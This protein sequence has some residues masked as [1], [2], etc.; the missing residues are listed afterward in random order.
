MKIQNQQVKPTP[1]EGFPLS[2]PQA[3]A[4]RGRN[5][6][7]IANTIVWVRLD[8]SVDSQQLCNQIEQTIQQDPQFSTGFDALPGMALP[9]QVLDAN[10][11]LC[12]FFV[13]DTLIDIEQEIAR[14]SQIPLGLNENPVVAVSI[15]G[16]QCGSEG[17]VLMLA[18]A[19]FLADEA[20]L[21]I[22]LDRAAKGAEKSLADEV[23]ALRFQHFSEWANKEIQEFQEQGRKDFWGEPL[24]KITLSKINLPIATKT[25]RQVAIE[26]I[27]EDWLKKLTDYGRPEAAFLTAWGIVAGQ[28][29]YDEAES[30]TISRLATGRVFDDFSEIIGS[31]SGRTPI[32]ITRDSAQ[33]IAEVM[34]TVDEAIALHE[35][36]LIHYPDFEPVTQEPDGATLGFAWIAASVPKVPFQEV[37][38]E[39]ATTGGNLEL[40][41]EPMA[42]G[43]RIRVVVSNL[44]D[45]LEL[46]ER[47]AKAVIAAIKYMSDTPEAALSS[48]PLLGSE[49]YRQVVTTWNDT[50]QL[51]T[52]PSSIPDGFRQI[53][54]QQPAELAVVDRLGELT[55][56]ELDR[57]SE[58]LAH[59]LIHR[60]IKKETPIA[61]L[62]NRSRESI[63]S[64]LAILKAGGIYVPINPDFPQS[65]IRQMLTTAKIELM[66]VEEVQA[67][68]TQNFDL[69]LLIV[70]AQ[71]Q[72][73]NPVELVSVE[74]TPTDAAY[75]IFTSGSTGV[76]KGVLVEHRS[77]LNLWQALRARIYHNSSPPL[78]VSV[79]AP[80][81]FDAS[82]KQMLQILSGHT[83]YLVPA[84]VRVDPKQMLAFLDRYRLN[85]FDCTPS[86]LQLLINAGL[87]DHFSGLPQRIL[88]GGEPFTPELWNL[89]SS[90]QHT[91]VFNLY[92]PTEATVNT[93]VTEVNLTEKQPNIGTPLPNVRVYVLDSHGRPKMISAP[94]EL[95]IAG[96]GIA[97]GY[98]NTAK[99]ASS[100]FTQNPFSDRVEKMYR[101]GDRVHWRSDGRL[102]F[103]GRADRQIKLKGYRI[104]LGDIDNALV[105]HPAVNESVTVL[106]EE[107]NGDSYLA[108]YAVLDPQAVNLDSPSKLDLEIPTG[109]IVAS[110]NQHETTYLYKE[111]FV[112]RCYLRNGI[113]LPADAVVFDVGANI[114][115]F[116]LFVAL[117]APQAHIYAFEPL[118]PIKERLQQNI[119][120]YAHQVTLFS[121][122]LSDR[123]RQETFTYYPGYSMMSGQ[124]NYA[125]AAGEVEVI[126]RYLSNEQQTGIEETGLLLNNL[127]TILE[128]KFQLEEHQC[129][130]RRL[131]DVLKELNL[132]RIDLLKIDVQRAE[133]DV[134][135]GLERHD[136]SKIKQVVLEVH[137]QE[138]G[139][140]AGNVAELTKLLKEQG[141]DVQIR[142]DSLLEGTDRF[143]CYAVRPEYA[144]QLDNLVNF[145]ETKTVS[146]SL[147]K[148]DS[149]NLR[150]FLE[151]YLP[152]YMLPQIVSPIARL[153]LTPEGKIDYRSLPAPQ[154][155]YSSRDIVLP[156]NPTEVALVGIWE[157]ILKQSPISVT[158]NFFQLGGDSIR[159]IQMQALAHE[160]GLSFS[161]RDLFQHQTIHELAM[162]IDAEPQPEISAA[163]SS[164]TTHYRPFELI[165][166]EDRAILPDGLV[167]AYPMTTLQLSMAYLTETVGVPKVFHNVTVH[168][169]AAPLKPDVLQQTLTQIVNRHPIL[170]TSFELT[171]YSQPLQL[172]WNQVN[173]KVPIE[174][175]SN[176]DAEQIQMN[177]LEA[178]NREHNTKFEFSVAP[179]VRFAAFK[180]DSSSYALL[181]A[182][183]HSILDGWSL[184]TLITEI[185]YVYAKTI[186]QQPISL[187]ELPAVTYRDFVLLENKAVRDPNS[188]VFWVNELKKAPVF[189]LPN[190]SA[191]RKAQRQIAERTIP[192]STKALSELKQLSAQTMLP[193][194]SLL[195]GVHLLA[196][197]QYSGQNN[198]TTGFVTSGR[199][200]E[201][202]ADEILGLFLNIVPYYAATK[203]LSPVDLA[204]EAFEFERRLL[205]HQR[206]P[207]SE[208]RRKCGEPAFFDSIFNFTHFH[209]IDEYASGSIV[210]DV[211]SSVSVDVD[212][213]LAVDFQI[214]DF[215]QQLQISFQYDARQF[216]A[217]EVDKIVGCYLK[218]MDDLLVRPYQVAPHQAISQKR[219]RLSSWI[220]EVFRDTLG[221][222]VDTQTG[223]FTAGGDSLSATKVVSELRQ[224]TG[225]PIPLSIMTNDPTIEE[226]ANSVRISFQEYAQVTKPPSLEKSQRWLVRNGMVDEPRLRLF[227]FPPAGASASMFEGWQ[228]CFPKEIEIIALQYPGRQE[229]LQEPPITNMK[230]LVCGVAEAITPLIDRPFALLGSSLG[231][232]V[233]FETARFLR[234]TNN[235][236]PT[237]LFAVC[238]RAPQSKEPYPRFHAMTDKELIETLRSFEGMPPEVLNNSEL[239]NLVLPA[240]RSDSLISSSYSYQDDR[241]FTC[242]IITIAGSRDHSVS[243][244]Q[245][246]SWAS[247]TTDVFELKMIDGGH[248][249]ID[250]NKQELINL[251]SSYNL[252]N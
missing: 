213:G 229:R 87:D 227:V 27:P 30:L 14:L 161:I 167:D 218:S 163:E 214:D 61:V 32:S 33:S 54:K 170:R 21:L 132:E 89:V 172:V 17:K 148:A 28:F 173:L 47:L 96:E 134:L 215:A 179:L 175:F 110:I 168:K 181:V 234:N 15:L 76:P 149:Q 207:L 108:S 86:L 145:D 152:A 204:G 60:G 233:A 117:Y 131:T 98:L 137:D 217:T 189:R 22:L 130:L 248:G 85:V 40:I 35:V 43:W 154:T 20:S 4:W 127:E 238:A 242:P 92:G 135:R 122:G 81:S 195:L 126:R 50:H 190:Y 169:I 232:L 236:E 211:L 222:P 18:T 84:D 197:A 208:I 41:V 246:E 39:P 209:S 250:S 103:L 19:P 73:N 183:H 128:E 151:Q 249:L 186:S 9:V 210:R 38:T 120:R 239:L 143:N 199:P 245:S 56:A 12:E 57:W 177:L 104:E 201:P 252:V 155:S 77:A 139:A 71:A 44:N 6:G 7:T 29:Q 26:V 129:Q 124:T 184:H 102:I 162:T 64:F 90:W 67:E 198:V 219:D 193:L 115:M 223:F 112:D 251:I 187:Q 158:D 42:N 157:N 202:R 138:G 228:K 241:P 150:D 37:Y 237:C 34:T 83:L 147:H 53:V 180:L 45:E 52:L 221:Y 109:H 24:D 2:P 68:K 160:Q 97:R 66:L 225:K 94:G 116:S 55:F 192:T 106:R 58:Q 62:A 65:R 121:E 107:E 206:Y 205:P 166:P 82:I 123:D 200:E 247:Q 88:V 142:Q 63:V 10:I 74:L 113:V 164:E 78:R 153:P 91:K 176:L 203:G 25:S 48:V 79:N 16:E 31:F 185:G 99:L 165:E 101:S 8:S 244:E 159:S 156:S 114:G 140:T 136:W 23:E 59:Q 46:A 231:A 141:F 3:R 72:K 230:Q 216:S 174:D 178:V 1:I 224:F 146:A 235:E 118:P 144:A 212:L 105:Q 93:T 13:S 194:R 133:L 188:A 111:I 220:A 80:F 75:I 69:D 226:I 11:P 125:D 196:L 95:C 182:E 100:P 51:F 243:L 5:H 36:A 240:I 49:E 171:Y 119:Q 191:I 70:N